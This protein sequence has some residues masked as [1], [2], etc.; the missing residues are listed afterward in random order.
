[1]DFEDYEDKIKDRLK[2]EI[3]KILQK[4]D[5][6]IEEIKFFMEILSSIRILKMSS[7]MSLGGK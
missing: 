4:E 3:E 1:M 7:L 6:K 5:L 2:T